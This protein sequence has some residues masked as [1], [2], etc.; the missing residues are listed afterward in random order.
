MIQTGM[1]DWVTILSIIQGSNPFP[2]TPTPTLTFL[3]ILTLLTRTKT[4]S[5]ILLVHSSR[6]S[7]SR[8]LHLQ[9]I[10][11]VHSRRTRTPQSV[12][13]SILQ[14]TTPRLGPL[15]PLRH[16]HPN[17]YTT[18][19]TCTSVVRT[20]TC[21]TSDPCRITLV[22]APLIC[23]AHCS[24]NTCTIPPTKRCLTPPRVPLVHHRRVSPLPPS[25][26]SISILLKF[27]APTFPMHS[28]MAS[29]CSVT[30]TCSPLAKIR[31]MKTMKEGLSLKGR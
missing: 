10:T 12:P 13:L 5:S 30:R 29:T 26:C 21:G 16:L 20:P 9:S 8:Q 18:T 19:S 31:I 11:M 14:S 2:R 27:F 24:L 7:H 28:H 3:S 6:T 1:P 25:R 15:I 22:V 17:H 23:L 4:R